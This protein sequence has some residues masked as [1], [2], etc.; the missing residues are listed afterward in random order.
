LWQ[1]WETLRNRDLPNIELDAA[2]T[3]AAAEA[4]ERTLIAAEVRRLELAA[5][6]A[7]LHSGE[8]VVESRIPGIE[9]PVRLGGDGTATVGDFAP[10]SWV[11]CCASPTG[12][13]PG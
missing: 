9:H 6:W 2:G 1:R 11:V 8:A 10:P 4:N 7:D 13:R 3:L 12:Q 5:H